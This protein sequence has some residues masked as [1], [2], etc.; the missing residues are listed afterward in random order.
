MTEDEYKTWRASQEKM[1]P[2]QRVYPLDQRGHRVYYK[3]EIDLTLWLRMTTGEYEGMA[4]YSQD[5]LLSGE[6]HGC[7]W[8]G[9]RVLANFDGERVV[10]RTECPAVD[11]APYSIDLPV[12][13]GEMVL[14]DDLRPVFLRPSDDESYH[15]C[16]DGVNTA[17]GQ[18]EEALW[19]IER[20]C[21][22]GQT[23]NVSRA[24]YRVDD[25]HYVIAEPAFN[26]DE[27]SLDEMWVP[28]EWELMADIDGAV[29]CYNVADAG[30]WD[31]R[32]PKVLAD[33]TIDEWERDRWDSR[34]Q[35]ERVKVKPGIYK[36][37][38]H[39]GERTFDHDSSDVKIYAHIERRDL[40]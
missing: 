1:M 12:P 33:E 34:R 4:K 17:F 26:E 9:E 19:M 18:R 30:E 28:P 16:P 3:D 29:W 7:N 20:G 11:G 31:R 39:A 15:R 2:E 32:L 5:T 23:G 38:H 35:P 6:A 8:C 14:A 37:T 10:L 27:D 13:S 24:L 21:A 40:V 25:D 36:F 22:Y